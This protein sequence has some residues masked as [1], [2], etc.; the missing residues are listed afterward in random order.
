[1]QVQRQQKGSERQAQVC[2]GIAAK[3]SGSTAAGREQR[4]GKRQA[5]SEEGWKKLKMAQEGES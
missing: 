2:R 5:T 4:R 1:V 3:F